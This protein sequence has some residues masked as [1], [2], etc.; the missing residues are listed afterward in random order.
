MN[1]KKIYAK[2]K[3]LNLSNIYRN[4]CAYDFL[5]SLRIVNTNFVIDR[6]TI[7]NHEIKQSKFSTL[8]KNFLKKFRNYLLIARALIVRKATHE[9]F[10]TLQEKSKNDEKSY[11]KKIRS[12]RS[13]NESK[14]QELIFFYVKKII[15]SITVII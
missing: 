1:W 7:L 13:K 4:W 14:S 3:R 9:T 11:Q 6:K 5:N 10:V 2:M 8:I 12:I 15:N